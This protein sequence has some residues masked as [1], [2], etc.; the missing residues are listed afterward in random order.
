MSALMELVVDSRCCLARMVCISRSDARSLF[1]SWTVRSVKTP[2]ALILLR[3][4]TSLFRPES[5]EN[6]S[7]SRF[8]ICVWI[9]W[10]LPRMDRTHAGGTDG[11][12]V[13]DLR[14]SMGAVCP[15]L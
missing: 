10:A 11:P 4:E 8:P 5:P 7:C 2:A 9:S 3:T 15:S 6:E 13:Y 1:E 14:A 12:R